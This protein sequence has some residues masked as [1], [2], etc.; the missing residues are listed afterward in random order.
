MDS[1][2]IAD[3]IYD[4]YD[5][6]ALGVVQYSLY[7]ADC[8]NTGAGTDG[9]AAAGANVYPNPFDTEAII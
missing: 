2:A 7:K 5:N 4:A 8:A 1:I 9:I 3:K 6:I